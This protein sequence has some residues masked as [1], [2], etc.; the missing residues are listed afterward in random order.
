MSLDNGQVPLP[1][2][3]TGNQTVRYSFVRCAH[4]SPC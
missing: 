3:P 4:T 1:G 2:I